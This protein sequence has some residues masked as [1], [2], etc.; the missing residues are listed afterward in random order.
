MINSA[1]KLYRS[2]VVYRKRRDTMNR[3]P[4][5]SFYCLLIFLLQS[6][7]TNHIERVDIYIM[8]DFSNT[9]ENSHFVYE[10]PEVILLFETA[11]DHAKQEPGIVDIVEPEYKFVL[12]EESY[13]LW[14]SRE[15]GTIMNVEDTHRV[16]SLTKKSAQGIYQLLKE[17]KIDI[18]G[19]S[20]LE[21]VIASKIR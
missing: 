20:P 4:L 17:G 3:I 6:C 19:N 21:L 18:I 2:L 9:K 12:G 8:N 15:H 5:F 16:S 13:F 10:D 7:S 14:I 1:L 11:I